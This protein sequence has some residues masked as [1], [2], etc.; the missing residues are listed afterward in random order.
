M[1]AIPA[2]NN[3]PTAIP[4]SII[5]SGLAPLILEIKRIIETLIRLNAKALILIIPEEKI[6][7][8][9]KKL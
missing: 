1:A 5:I 4:L 3:D 6:F 9:F 7:V 8:P 2:V